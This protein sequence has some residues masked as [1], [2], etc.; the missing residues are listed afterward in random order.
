MVCGKFIAAVRVGVWLS[1]AVCAGVPLYAQQPAP[2]NSKVNER[3]RA[4]SQATAD[5]QKNN[6]SDV[7]IT[8]DIRKAIVAD[9][10]LS[11]Y[12]HNVK[13]ITQHGEVTL[14]GPVR[15]EDEKRT[16]ESKA[17]EIAGAGHVKN[18][19]SIT[20]ATPKAKRRVHKA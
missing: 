16:V 14:K 7:A 17:S 20:D 5:Q 12:A 2:D 13:V 3:D 19:L 6:R 1:V 9:K 11:T 10:Q 18:Q 4:P 15:T 8:R